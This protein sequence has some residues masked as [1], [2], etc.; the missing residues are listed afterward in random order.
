MFFPEFD[1]YSVED[2][3]D[4]TMQF[5]TTGLDGKQYIFTV[6]WSNKHGGWIDD[7]YQRY[8]EYYESEN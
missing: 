8:P 1:D 3:N 4:Y 5:T 6:A 7:L 2:V